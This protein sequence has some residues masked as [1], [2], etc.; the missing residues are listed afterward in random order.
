MS[1]TIW[2]ATTSELLRATRHPI[3][4]RCRIPK[5]AGRH[6]RS[7]APS[8][9]IHRTW[10]PAATNDNY[11]DRPAAPASTTPRRR[12]PLH[13]VAHRHAAL[14][15]GGSLPVPELLGE[16]V[17]LAET[18]RT[19]RL[20]LGQQA[21][22][23]IDREP[24]A[25]GGVA[26]AQQAASSPACRAEIPVRKQLGP[27]SVSWHSTRSMS[28]GRLPPP[29]RRARRRVPSG[30]S[31]AAGR[32]QRDEPVVG[33][34]R[35][36]RR[37]ADPPAQVST[38]LRLLVAHEHCGCSTLVRRAQHEQ[39]ERRAHMRDVRTSS[40]VTGFRYMA[41]GLSTAWPCSSH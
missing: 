8:R 35:R 18:R 38:S 26:A 11:S 25:K 36:V 27:L 24:A 7:S 31:G 34:S 22:R 1:F 29:G 14:G 30:S 16:L 12:G 17:H 40:R 39:R 5:D 4:E 41:L 32:R 13:H 10:S 3:A 28:P 33:P 6:P 21:P 9:C 2:R 37:R 20:T 19:E 15:P 23:G